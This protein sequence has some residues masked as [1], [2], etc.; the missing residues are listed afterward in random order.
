MR[1]PHLETL[2]SDVLEELVSSRPFDIPVGAKTLEI[3]GRPITLDVQGWATDENENDGAEKSN[4]SVLL[5]GGDKGVAA[6]VEVKVEGV[7]VVDSGPLRNLF[8]YS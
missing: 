7:G 8:P 4:C 5:E 3:E 2:S 1:S 6:G